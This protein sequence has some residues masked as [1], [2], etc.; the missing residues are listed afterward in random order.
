[1]K[2]RKIAQTPGLVAT[3]VDNLTNSSNVDALSANQG[4]IL[5]ENKLNF[6]YSKK[7]GDISILVNKMRFTVLEGAAM[8]SNV[9]IDFSSM[10]SS[11]NGTVVTSF[12]IGQVNTQ[13][14]V[15]VTSLVPTINQGIYWN[16]VARVRVFSNAPSA[17]TLVHVGV[18]YIP[19]E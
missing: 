5:N 16:Y 3:V 11:L 7:T 8:G 12:V 15:N 10:Y 14:N 9:E 18:F 2:I 6:E 4:K 1:M 19:N 13:S 17:T